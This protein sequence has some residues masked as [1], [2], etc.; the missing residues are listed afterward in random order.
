MTVVEHRIRRAQRLSATRRLGQRSLVP[1]YQVFSACS[2]P[3]GDEAIRT[4]FRRS[5]PTAV[6]TRAQRLSATRRLGRNRLSL[7]LGREDCAQRL[8]ATRRLGLESVEVLVSADK[9]STP[10]GDEAIRTALSAESARTCPR[11]QRLSATR[12]LGQSG[13]SPQAGATSQG[14]QRLSATR[15]L[16]PQD[17]ANH[18]VVVACSTPFGDEAIRTGS[19]VRVTFSIWSAQRLSATRRLGPTIPEKNACER[20]QCSTPFGDEAIRTRPGRGLR[21][22]EQVLNAFRRRGD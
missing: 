11:A 10:F 20:P 22:A 5:M 15:R 8:S 12:R 7:S 13:S 16:G 18:A 3:F 4:R 6:S 1:V 19:S 14:A 17:L 9:C 21:G 2:T